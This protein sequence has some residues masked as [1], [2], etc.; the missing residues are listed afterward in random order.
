[1]HMYICLTLGRMKSLYPLDTYS[2]SWQE[3]ESNGGFGNLA[4]VVRSTRVGSVSKALFLIRATAEFL[5]HPCCVH[6]CY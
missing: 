4:E 2:P 1:M 3:T 5:F 6:Y